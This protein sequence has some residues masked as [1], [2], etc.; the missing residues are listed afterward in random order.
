MRQS[1]NET[2]SGSENGMSPRKRKVVRHTDLDV[3]QRAFSAAMVVFRL[4]RNFPPEERYSLTD[5]VRRSSRSVCSNLAEGWRKRRYPASFVSKL[6]DSEG[7]AAETQSWLQFAVECGYL[8]GT[9]TRSLYTDYDYIIGMLVKMQ[10]DP[11]RWTL[12]P[13]K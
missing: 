8:K 9:D 13:R 10:N 2:I 7:E 5:Q 4:S 11:T 12:T 6:N 1:D 3:Y